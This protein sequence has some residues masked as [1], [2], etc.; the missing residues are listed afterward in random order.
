MRDKKIKIVISSEL[1]DVRMADIIAEQLCAYKGIPGD[2]GSGLRLCLAEAVNNSI[3]HA[4][5][6]KSGKEV[7]ILFCFC[8][9]RVILQVC[10]TGISINRSLSD[11]PRKHS[12]NPEHTDFIPTCGRGFEIIKGFMD[13]VEYVRNNQKNCL[14]MTKKLK[15]I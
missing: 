9:D 6:Q 12:R 1:E 5:G 8:P 13:T 4:Y 2:I 15:G 3:I 11:L 7:E 10:D 14:I